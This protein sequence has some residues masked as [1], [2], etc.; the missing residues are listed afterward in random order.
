MADSRYERLKDVV[1]RAREVPLADRAAFLDEACA[2]DAELR[3]E[4]ASL[5]AHDISLEVLRTAAFGAAAPV[6]AA[7]PARPDRIGPYHLGDVLGEGGMGVVYRAEQIEP[8]QRPV[9]LKLVRR[10]MDTERIVARFALERQTLAVMNHPHI[11]RVFDA[12]ATDDGRPYFVMEL[13]EGS[14]I[15]SYAAGRRLSLRARLDLFLAVCQGVRHAHQKGVIHRDLKPSNVL[16]AE[17]DSRPVPKIIDFG[18]AK[19]VGESAEGLTIGAGLLGT[20]AYMSPEQAGVSEAP[21]DTRTDVY[22]LGVLLYE[23]LTGRPPYAIQSGTPAEL[24]RVL[25]DTTPVRPSAVVPPPPTLDR[26]DVVGDLDSVVLKAIEIDPDRRYAS[27]EQLADDLER[28]LAGRPVEARAAVWTYRARKFVGR[29]RVGVGVAAGVFGLLAASLAVTAKSLIDVRRERDV[30]RQA[31]ETA[32][33]TTDFLVNMIGAA[34]PREPGVGIKADVR[35]R[36]ALASAAARVGEAFRDRPAVEERLRYEIGRTYLMLGEYEPACREIQAAVTIARRQYGPRDPR[37]LSRVAGLASCET[38]AGRV[39]D[40][41]THLTPSAEFCAPDPPPTKDCQTILAAVGNLRFYQARY[42]ESE[43]AYRRALAL[44]PDEPDNL[45]RLEREFGLAKAIHEQG[46]YQQAEPLYQTV[47]DGLRRTQGDDYLLTLDVMQSLG[48]L[49]ESTDR[50][51]KALELFEHIAAEKTR[52]LGAD[53]AE[54]LLARNQLAGAYCNTGQLDR[55]LEAIKQ[56]VDAKTRTI[57]PNHPSTI[58]SDMNY[59][60]TLFAIG[61]R[62][63]AVEVAHNA[64]TRA[65]QALPAGH[66]NIGLYLLDY[67]DM[68]TKV[69]RWRDADAPARE[70]WRRVVA[71]RNEQF[72]AAR[73]IAGL[74][75]EV[76]DHTGRPS[77]AAT[78]RAKAN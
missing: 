11:A 58:L 8:I 47:I 62:E 6:A 52:L 77:E 32:D 20:P 48:I 38:Q 46:H 4:A 3:A 54:T 34:N 40:A 60:E 59:A 29:H 37:T 78:W 35:V 9:A 51:P 23:L 67:A 63:D 39:A 24:H 25:K 31:S 10:G 73:R 72:P 49:Y 19:A 21:V 2:G 56:V 45:Q 76:C 30:A 15:T 71:A 16:V 22:A 12:G 53:T 42:A 66:V 5:L 43:T 75:A 27:V 55:C 74:L 65:K 44:M 7:T 41:E 70:A 18:I 50:W 13:V 36:D 69:G 26:R 14:S 33:A 17:V 68:L 64:S 28:Y 1:T 61:R 57:G